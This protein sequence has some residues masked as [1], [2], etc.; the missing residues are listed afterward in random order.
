MHPHAHAQSGV[1][2][3]TLR[4]KLGRL[5]KEQK[6]WERIKHIRFNDTLA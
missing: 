2:V 1:H 4:E 3:A 6:C 5:H